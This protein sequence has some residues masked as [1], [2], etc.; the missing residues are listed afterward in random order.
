VRITKETKTPGHLTAGEA[1]KDTKGLIFV[2]SGPSGSGKSTLLVRLVH[3]KGFKNRMVRSISCTT[4]PKRSGEINNKDYFFISQRQFIEKRKAK[5]ILEWTKYLGYYYATPRDFLDTQIEKGL[6]VVMCLDVKG[7]LRV[8]RLY[9][10]NTVTIFVLPPS[11]SVLKSRLRNRC[12]KT[13]KEE[14]IKRLEL[15]NSEL[16]AAKKFDYCI[17]NSKLDEAIKRLKTIALKEKILR[18]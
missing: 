10:K 7:S 11:L 3:S 5:K 8:K 15:A 17:V 18:Q 2:I 6:D 4:R 14:I 16:E 1:G 12:N 9:P 13:K